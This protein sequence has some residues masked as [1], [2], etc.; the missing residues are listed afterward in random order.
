MTLD[1]PLPLKEQHRLSDFDCG[2]TSLNEWLNKR[3]KS[4]Q[5]SGASRTYVVCD[6]G[7]VVAFYSLASGGVTSLSCSGNIKRNMPNPIPVVFLA[8]LA[9]ANSHKRRGI[10]RALVRDAV[11]RVVA[12][13]ETIGIRAFV[14]HAIDSH[15]KEFYQSLGFES[16]PL[17]PLM[18]MA[19]LTSLRL[20]LVEKI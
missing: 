7:K 16:S 10:G 19:T 4:N 9:V 14:I 11:I 12:A 15:A 17:D 18:L 5:I 1:A 8:R 2:E 3:A 13:A 20:N 6:N